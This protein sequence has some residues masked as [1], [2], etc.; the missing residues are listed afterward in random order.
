MRIRRKTTFAAIGAL[1]VT[2]LFAVDGR[3]ALADSYVV[4]GPGA[5]AAGY[6]TPRMVVPKG[7][8]AYFVNLDVATHDVVA[9]AAGTYGG[10]K[11]RS[12]LTPTGQK[13]IIQG[14][15]LLKAGTFPFFCSLHPNMQGALIVV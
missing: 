13:K 4:A 7:S 15:N 14:V 9:K 10:K 3:Q 5:V 2:L 12:A 1:L 8:K 11:F 6:L